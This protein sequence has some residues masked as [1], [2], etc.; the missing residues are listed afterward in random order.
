MT[1]LF[2][3][4]DEIIGE[5]STANGST[6]SIHRAGCVLMIIKLKFLS[7]ARHYSVPPNMTSVIIA[8]INL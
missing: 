6:T 4:G 3:A 1:M 7:F 8:L 2:V 5:Q